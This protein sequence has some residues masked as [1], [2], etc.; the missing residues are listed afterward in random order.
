MTQI[1]AIIGKAETALRTP[2]FFLHDTFYIMGFASITLAFVLG[3]LA[4]LKPGKRSFEPGSFWAHAMR[5]MRAKDAPVLNFE[6]SSRQWI[7][8]GFLMLTCGLVTGGSWA[9]E[10][11]ENCGLISWLI[12]GAVLHMH[13]APEFKGRKALWASVFAWGF[14]LITYVGV[15]KLPTHSQSMGMSPERPIIVKGKTLNGEN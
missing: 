7:R 15:G 6:T 3:I 14:V 8:F 11:K 4:L 1:Y 2:L 9:W 10:A 5:A 12:Y 13:Y